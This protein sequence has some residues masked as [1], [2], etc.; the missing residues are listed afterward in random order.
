MLIPRER[1]E[2]RTARR[3]GDDH[4]KGRAPLTQVARALIGPVAPAVTAAGR[5]RVSPRTFVIHEVFVPGFSEYPLGAGRDPK[6]AER[7]AVM[8]PRLAAGLLLTLALV[9][10]KENGGTPVGAQLF[11]G[12]GDVKVL[13]AQVVSSGDASAQT[14]GG[15]L[16]YV[17]A[18]VEFTND[19]GTDTVPQ[20]DHFYLIDQ[21]GTRFQAKDSGSSVFTGVSNSQ[22]VLKKDEKREYTIG[23]RTTSANSSGTIFYER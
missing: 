4:L 11:Q 2:C 14:S 5:G 3:A 6:P 13:N 1:G 17:I 12:V 23:F 10:C 20:I 9:A 8:I 21:N 18:K 19:L 16:S 22:T 15:T 7:P